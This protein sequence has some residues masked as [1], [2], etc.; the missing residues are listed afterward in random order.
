MTSEPPALTSSPDVSQPDAEQPKAHAHAPHPALQLPVDLLLTENRCED[1][2][3]LHVLVE[4]KFSAI[5]G[6]HFQAVPSHPDFFFYC[7]STYL[8]NPEVCCDSVFTHHFFRD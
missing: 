5:M 8:E 1:L 4:K 7:P 6:R 3:E 2:R